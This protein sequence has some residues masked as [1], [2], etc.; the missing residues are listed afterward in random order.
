[1]YNIY[2]DLLKYFGPTFMNPKV[3]ILGCYSVIS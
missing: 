2:Q 3:R 1:M